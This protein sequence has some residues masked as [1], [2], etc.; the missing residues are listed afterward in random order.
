MF[1]LTL[2]YKLVRFARYSPHAIKYRTNAVTCL[3]GR[4]QQKKKKLLQQSYWHFL[5][6][7]LRVELDTIID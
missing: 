3:H 7:K 5:S 6:Q 4:K 1:K 2:S